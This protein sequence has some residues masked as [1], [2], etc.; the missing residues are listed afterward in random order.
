MYTCLLIVFDTLNYDLHIATSMH[1]MSTVH[2]HCIH[3]MQSIYQLIST[4]V[5][6]FWSTMLEL[7]S[8]CCPTPLVGVIGPEFSLLC[9]LLVLSRERMMLL[10]DTLLRGSAQIKKKYISECSACM[11]FRIA[12]Y[13]IFPIAYK[14][15]YTGSNFGR[16]AELRQFFSSA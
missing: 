10:L 7:S 3:T 9:K 14:D 5:H 4:S 15:L 11:C 8:N 16:S 12:A 2:G 6:G 13:I 1:C